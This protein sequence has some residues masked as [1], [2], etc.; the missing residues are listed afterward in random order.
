MPGQSLAGGQLMKKLVS[1]ILIVT[2]MMMLLSSCGQNQPQEREVSLTLWGP[3]AAQDLLRQMADDFCQKHKDQAKIQISV[4]VEEENRLRD[5]IVDNKEVAADVFAF[6][7]DQLGDLKKAEVLS[8]VSQD[9]EMVIEENGGKEGQSVQA[10]SLDGKLYAYPMTASNGYF[11]YYNKKYLSPEDVE[12]LDQIL[13]VCEK[14][15]KQFCMDWTSGWYIYS[16]FGGAG[17]SVSKNEDGVTNTCDFNK[18]EGEYRGT[19]V[20]KAMIK[21]KKSKAF[22]S[23]DD[24]KYIEGMKKGQIIAGVSGT[25]N[26]KAVEEAYGKDYAACKLPTYS[27]AGDQVQMKSF[28]SFKLVG[29]N[30]TSKEGEWAQKLARFITNEE[31]QKLRFEALGEGP[32][33]VNVSQL[34]VVK[35]S[36]A[37]SA[38][39]EQRP[40]S[41]LDNIGS[42]YWLP[43]T[44]LGTSILSDGIKGRRL[45]SVLNRFVKQVETETKE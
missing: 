39:N 31:N 9:L 43:S 1:K 41:V 27:L 30:A 34:D 42:S 19:D 18:T 24:Q 22:I 12:S 8:P 17:C 5:D 37:I 29:V 33:N 40:F 28:S 21:I 38:L 20:L 10:A 7:F 6:P 13:A 11:L 4:G 23:L 26:A 14:N 35:K 25:W 16:F 32:S 45:Q 15:K 36:V 2:M 3:E 44:V